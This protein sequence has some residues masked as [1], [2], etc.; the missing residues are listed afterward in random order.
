MIKVT[1]KRLISL[2]EL[3]KTKKYNKGING[4]LFFEISSKFIY[5]K[6]IFGEGFFYSPIMK[7]SFSKMFALKF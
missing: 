1:D 4:D 5:E 7:Y 6:K 2:C 3:Y